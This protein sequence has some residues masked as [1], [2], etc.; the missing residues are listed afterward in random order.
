MTLKKIAAFSDGQTGG[1]P[2]GVQFF[3][4]LPDATVMQ[5]TAAEVGFSEC[6]FAAPLEGTSKWR[7]RYFSPETE[8][9]FCGHATIALGAA[10]AQNHGAGQFELALNEATI[11]VEG[12][13]QNGVASATL[14]SPPTRNRVLT[15]EELAATLGL[16][17]LSE[18]QLDTRIPPAWVHAG[19]DH[20]ML[21]LKHRADLAAMDYDLEAGKSFMRDRALV[22]VMLVQAQSDRTFNIRNP[23][24]SGGVFEDPATGAAMAAFSGYLRDTGLRAPGII[25]GV[26]GEDMGMLSKLTAEFDGTKGA[27]IK[28]SGQTR[29][30]SR[31]ESA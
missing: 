31:S 4:T 3:E 7:V 18:D 24:A 21:A 29:V 19:A 20:F 15:K 22:T 27:S 23:F 14:Q 12:A 25:H 8:V 17:G 6:V 28:V 30:M 13:V 26:Q 2:A 5:A 9:P 16:F 1:N 11:T 10:L